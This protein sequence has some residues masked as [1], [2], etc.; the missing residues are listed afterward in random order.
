MRLRHERSLVLAPLA[1]AA[2]SSAAPAVGRTE[3]VAEQIHVAA[4][5]APHAL[6]SAI[7][8]V[9]PASADGEGSGAEVVSTASRASGET[10]RV[11]AYGQPEWT[12]RRRFARTRVYVLPEGQ[13]EFEQWWRGTFDRGEAAGHLFQTEIGM[14][15]ADRFQI[16]LYGNAEHEDG[17]TKWLGLQ[18]ELRWAP[19]DWGV[20]PLNP[21]I[22]LEYKWIHGGNDVA[23]G[24]ILLGEEL[25]RDLH[26]GMNLS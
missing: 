24:K 8:A 16:D 12:T 15:L 5:E 14:G 23:E 6:D 18:P 2:C 1:L 17:T 26:W 20:L 4:F 25:S 22:Y 13:L 7:A 3:P 19:A 9:A 21:T 11:G 10:E